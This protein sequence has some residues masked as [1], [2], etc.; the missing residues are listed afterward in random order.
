MLGVQCGPYLLVSSAAGIVGGERGPRDDLTTN[1]GLLSLGFQS[2]R[3][4]CVHLRLYHFGN[5][6]SR[7]VHASSTLEAW[8]SFVSFGCPSSPAYMVARGYTF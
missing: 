4:P 8:L 3:G 1:S 5:R 7:T 6:V 2:L